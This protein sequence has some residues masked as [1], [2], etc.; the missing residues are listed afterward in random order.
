[1]GLLFLYPAVM[2]MSYSIFEQLAGFE[3]TEHA[4]EDDLIVE[5]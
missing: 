2:L 1:V 5:D 4:L 3:G